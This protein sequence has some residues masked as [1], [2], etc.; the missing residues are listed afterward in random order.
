VIYASLVPAGIEVVSRPTTVW[1]IHDGAI[2]RIS[3]YQERQDALE[4][5]GLSAQDAPADS[6]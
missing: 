4:A 6:S 1:T 3:M 2:G 5:V